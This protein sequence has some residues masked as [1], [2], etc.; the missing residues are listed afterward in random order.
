MEGI[1]SRTVF[2]CPLSDYH[3]FHA[4]K[5]HLRDSHF[6]YQAQLES[7][8]TQFFKSQPS[9]F[10]EKGICEKVVDVNDDHFVD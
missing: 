8:M 5:Q 4:L 3:Y 9:S 6:D 2:A 1:T 7:E 10:W